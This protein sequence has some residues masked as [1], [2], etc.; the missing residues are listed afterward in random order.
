MGRLRPLIPL[1]LLMAWAVLVMREPKPRAMVLAEDLPPTAGTSVVT[2]QAAPDSIEALRTRIAAVLERERVPGV[3]IA[4]VGREGIRWVGGVGVA[5]LETGAPVTAHTVFRVASITKSIVGLGVA[6]LVGQGRLSLDRPLAEWLPG[7][8]IDNP[9]D[10]EAPVTLAHALEHTAGFDDMRFNE[11]FAEDEGMTPAQALALNP[12][13]RVVRWRP[14]SRMAYSNVG[15]TVA[16]LAIE[17]ATGEPFD[18]WLRAQILAPLGIHEATFG[19]TATRREYLATGYLAPDRAARFIP[20]AHRPAGALLATPAE[21]ARLVSFWLRRG[22]PLVPPEGLDRI[23]RAATLE[24]P[25]TDVAYGLGN[26]GD[27]GHPVRARGHDGGLPGFLSSYRYFPRLGV[28]YVMLLNSTHSVAAYLEI[29]GLLFAFLTRGLPRPEVPSAPPDPQRAEHAGYYEYAS[30]RMALLGFLDRALLGWSLH[31][32]PG[33]LWLTPALGDS[34]DL[35]PTGSGG[36]R[37][38]L[39]SGASVRIGFDRQGQRVLTVGWARAEPRAWLPATLRRWLL[40]LSVLLLQLA[41]L[42]GGLWL[43]QRVLRRRDLQGAGLWLWP[44]VAGLA[45]LAIPW[46]F[47]EA[48]A[49]SSLG[50]VD[51]ITLGLCAATLVLALASALGLASAVR[52]AVARTR[53]S[54]IVRLLPTLTSTLAVGL[55]LWLGAHGIIGLRTWAW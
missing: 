19:R 53:G 11:T 45:L 15:Y 12:R 23:E 48:V 14:G 18:A 49:R 37:H 7:L 6:R 46:L 51:E 22:P 1:L 20:I 16:G 35:V 42:V 4:L 21:L 17:Q 10:A 29:R 47:M 52:A 43:V 44:A 2:P 33:G 26:Y 32:S 5:D 38:A 9:W 25:L 41:P 24:G 34:V 39:D 30:P 13:S 54:W 28:G 3:G 40:G 36:Y 50:R 27:V 31:P 8:Q 55:T